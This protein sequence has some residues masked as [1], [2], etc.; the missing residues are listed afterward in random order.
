MTVRVDRHRI[1]GGDG[2]VRLRID[3][4]GVG[5]IGARVER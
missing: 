3:G 2:P 4:F 5:G 1:D